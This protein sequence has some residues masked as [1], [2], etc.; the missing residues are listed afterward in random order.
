MNGDEGSVLALRGD[1]DKRRW[2]G[3]VLIVILDVYTVVTCITTT[4]YT[5]R[6]P[7]W[8]AALPG[9]W[10]THKKKHF[11]WWNVSDNMCR[12][13]RWSF[14]SWFSVNRSIFEEDMRKNSFNIFVPIVTSTSNLLL[15]LLLSSAVFALNYKFLWLA[16]FEKIGGRGRTDGRPGGLRQLKRYGCV[17]TQKLTP[18]WTDAGKCFWTLPHTHSSGD[19]KGGKGW[20]EKGKEGS[21]RKWRKCRMEGM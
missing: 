15:W 16:C 17:T 10:L 20:K 14:L 5:A 8:H 13:G 6:W 2:V 3:H 12:M 21:E 7:L 18:T 1:V 19:R 9:Y 11:R 4:R